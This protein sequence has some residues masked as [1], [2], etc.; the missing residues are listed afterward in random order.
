MSDL[1][2]SM[3]VTKDGTRY[4]IL[5]LSDDDFKL[6]FPSLKEAK[7]ELKKLEILK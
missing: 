3:K 7:K 5:S 4:F 1:F 6:E 2:I